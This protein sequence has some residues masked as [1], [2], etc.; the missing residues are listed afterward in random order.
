M[1]ENTDQVFKDLQPL[2][3]QEIADYIRDYSVRNQYGLSNVPTH[4]H[5]GTDTL[6]VEYDNLTGKKFFIHTKIPGTNASLV[7][8]YGVFFIAP[9]ACNVL[10]IYEVHGVAGTDGGSVT[11]NVEKL[12]AGVALDSG[13]VLMPTAFNLKST[14]NYVTTAGLTTV[15]ATK[16]LAKG[17]RLALKDA[18]TLTSVADICVIIELTY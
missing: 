3:R 10:A 17:D 18:G 8:N 16:Q 13:T 1:P 14:A 11:L 6:Q 9:Y 5:T 7:T 2:I 12:R 15:L 4:S